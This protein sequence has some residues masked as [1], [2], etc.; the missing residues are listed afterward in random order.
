MGGYYTGLE[1]LG[2]QLLLIAGPTFLPFL[3]LAARR[4]TGWLAWAAVAAPLVA[5]WSY[6]VYVDTRP[7]A[8]GGA[9]FAALLGWLACLLAL[10]VAL[11]IVLASAVRARLS[12]PGLGGGEDGHGQAPAS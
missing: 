2:R 10:A 12:K 3:F 6:V 11:L 8:G 1:L 5:G 7:Y 4:R 9:S